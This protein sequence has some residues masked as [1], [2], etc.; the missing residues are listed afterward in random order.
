MK[1]VLPNNTPSINQVHFR[2]FVFRFITSY[3]YCFFVSF[4]ESERNGFSLRLVL[5]KHWTRQISVLLYVSSHRYVWCRFRMYSKQRTPVV[6]IIH[7][8]L[9][10]TSLILCH[11]SFCI[12]VFTT[13]LIFIVTIITSA[14]GNIKRPL[15][16]LLV[17]YIS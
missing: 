5:F 8:L 9:I 3:G 12:D 6:Y 4:T 10:P 14:G 11:L 1:P 16:L 17:F 15:A 2:C 13:R 7:D